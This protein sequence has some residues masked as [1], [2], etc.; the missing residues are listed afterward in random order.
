MTTTTT[1]PP[2]KNVVNWFE[3]P[4]SNIEQASALYAA[5]LDTKLEQS[6]FGGVPH[7]VISNADHSCV[8]GALVSDPKRPPNRGNGTLIYLNAPDG[9][10]RCVA[11]AVEAGA[12]VVQPLTPID[13]H[14]TI[15]LIEDLDGNVIGLHE[16][17]K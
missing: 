7:A 15:A 9:V 12:K 17:P 2:S 8:S 1:N 13:P 4:V 3:I 6:V 11:R 14:G 16:Q 5:M 10:A